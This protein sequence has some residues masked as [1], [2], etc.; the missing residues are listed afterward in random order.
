MTKVLLWANLFLVSLLAAGVAGAQGGATITAV[1]PGGL[2]GDSDGD[3]VVDADDNCDAAINPDQRDTD[4]DGFG[5]ACDAD[6]DN[7]G[8][9]GA[10]DFNLLRGAVGSF[11]GD[12]GYDANCDINGDGAIDDEDV[13]LVKQQLGG[14]PGP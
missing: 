13:Q 10:T 3:L 4:G 9:V 1:D 14:P 6:F 11:E 5:N 2:I 8:V 12:E 7:D